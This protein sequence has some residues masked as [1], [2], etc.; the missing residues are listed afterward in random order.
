LI[1]TECITRLIIADCCIDF[2]KTGGA[3]EIGHAGGN[4][5]LSRWA[6]H[7]DHGAPELLVWG[8]LWKTLA[9]EWFVV[10]TFF[11]I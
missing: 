7:S 2:P 4:T 10:C 5:P 6:K 8:C 11:D 1:C 3:G 9:W